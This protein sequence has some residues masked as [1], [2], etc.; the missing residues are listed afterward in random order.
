MGV[1]PFY[2]FYEAFRYPLLRSAASSMRQGPL[3]V[4][5]RHTQIYVCLRWLHFY[6]LW[7]KSLN[8]TKGLESLVPNARARTQHDST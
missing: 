5:N 6:P 4:C 7:S 3:S 2:L 8:S 1:G